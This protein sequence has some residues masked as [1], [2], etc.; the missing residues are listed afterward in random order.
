MDYRFLSFEKGKFDEMPTYEI[1]SQYNYSPDEWRRV[2]FNRQRTIIGTPDVVKEKM[3]A[4]AA[5]LD[6]EEVAAATFAETREDRFKSY[7]L[8]AAL[9][10]LTAEAPGRREIVE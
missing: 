10:L 9:F 8:L 1:A 4:L 6:V 2:L 7:E 3:L 5:A